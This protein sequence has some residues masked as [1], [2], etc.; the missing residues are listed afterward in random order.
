MTE[1]TS[2]DLDALSARLYPDMRRLARAQLRR[3]RP[4]QTL[5]T[6]AL[7]H[8]A[9]LKLGRSAEF[10]DRGHFLAASARAMR[11]I[12]VNAA[13]DRL[14]AKRGGGATDLELQEADGA[15]D[16]Q[17]ALHV[18]DVA[19]AMEDLQRLD[20]R[21]C[22]L[23]ECRY[24]AGMT[25]QETALALGLSERSVRRDWL[26]ARAWLKLALSSMEHA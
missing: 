19:R 8:E 17:P 4:G 2:A 7:V 22:R 14:A 9:Y 23:V 24:F 18:L 11:H 15:G 5:D 25:D 13:R 3:L 21:L 20:A 12:L 1:L 6:T 26:R 10:A 16:I